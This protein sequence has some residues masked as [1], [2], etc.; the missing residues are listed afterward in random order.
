[1]TVAE[2]LYSIILCIG[3]VKTQQ[4]DMKTCLKEQSLATI[5]I[6]Q[7]LGG[8]KLGDKGL[9]EQMQ[10]LKTDHYKVKRQVDRQGWFAGGIAATV[11]VATASIIAWAKS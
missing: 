6:Q 1:M 7:V 4:A 5:E 2:K 11:S 10:V 8:S 9:I 3:E